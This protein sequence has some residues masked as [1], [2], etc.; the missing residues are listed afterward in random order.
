MRPIHL[1]SA[2]AL[3]ALLAAGPARA[4][5][6]PMEGLNRRVHG[7][8]RLVQ[9]HVLGPA[10]ELYQASTSPGFRLGL[11]N[12][13]ANLA[14]PVSAASGLIAG[15][16][17]LAW[18][19]AARFGIN[20]TLGLGGVRDPATAM[21]YVRR[22]AGLADALCAWGV[23]SGPYL[24]LPLIGPST[25]R[26]AGALIATSA[27]LTQAI[28]ADAVVAWSA[29]D[30]LVDYA[31][32]HA[33]LGRIEAEAL[34]PYAVHRSAYLQRRAARCPGDREAAELP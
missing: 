13:V 8:N 25:I 15:D 16:L 1:T 5:D 29:T 9:T 10:A 23:P 20:A 14:E 26:D 4:A 6:D 12:V 24:V 32:A 28:G 18:N 3:A 34:D 31:E 7:F 30:R 19:A 2:M 33:A 22:P 21:G 27:A 17:D 11:A